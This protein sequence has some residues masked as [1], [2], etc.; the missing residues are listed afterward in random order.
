MWL[1]NVAK[2]LMSKLLVNPVTTTL[3]TTPLEPKIILAEA[4]PEVKTPSNKHL[5]RRLFTDSTNPL[6]SRRTIKLI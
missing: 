2:P 5:L 4:L 3:K 1:V 6:T